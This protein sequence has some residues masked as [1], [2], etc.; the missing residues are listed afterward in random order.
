MQKRCIGSGFTARDNLENNQE[1]ESN[2]GKN[3]TSLRS[4]E[5]LH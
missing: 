5:N 4:P 2:Q 1:C 3:K